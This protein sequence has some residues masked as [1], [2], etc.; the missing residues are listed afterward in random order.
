MTLGRLH[1]MMKR[2]FAFAIVFAV[3]PV[4][5]QSITP[6]IGGGISNG[7]DGGISGGGAGVLWTPLNLGSA[8]VAWWDAHSLSSSPV[9]SWVDTKSGIAATQGT[10][11]NQPTWS[12]TARNGTPGLSFN[13]T[14]SNLTFTPTGFPA[15][16]SAST[17]LVGGFLNTANTTNFF[18][19]L[20]YGTNAGL[21]LW[22]LSNEGGF[23]SMQNGSDN[24]KSTLSWNNLDRCVIVT[25]P[26]GSNPSQNIYVDGNTPTTNVRGTPNLTLTN[27]FIGAYFSAGSLWNGVI[28]QIV[29]MNRVATTSEAAKLAGWESWYDGKAGAN[30]PGGHPYKSRAPYVSDP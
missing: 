1:K 10:G 12:A 4:L 8:L 20:T 7:F 30:L 25:T 16:S 27:G 2:I 21:Q 28:Q 15:G 3:A 11:A 13:G 14:S 19:A 5:G 6:Q 9:S 29:V 23:A 24:G 18:S 22:S 17:F 26:T